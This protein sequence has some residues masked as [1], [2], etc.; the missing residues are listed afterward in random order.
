MKG[1][2]LE[3]RFSITQSILP[4]I[5]LIFVTTL[6]FCSRGKQCAQHYCTAKYKTM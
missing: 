1:A 2:C 4:A 3:D 6:L 5:A